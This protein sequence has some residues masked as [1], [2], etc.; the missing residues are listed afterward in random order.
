MHLV[1][2]D[3]EFDTI[4]ILLQFV[5]SEKIVWQKLTINQ[6]GSLKLKCEHAMALP[7]SQQKS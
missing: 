5:C 6:C 4:L 3:Q 2:K 7:Y 1:I